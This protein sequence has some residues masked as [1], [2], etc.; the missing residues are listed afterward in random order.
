MIFITSVSDVAGFPF[1]LRLRVLQ[2]GSAK[3]CSCTLALPYFPG[4]FPLRKLNHFCSNSGR[5]PDYIGSSTSLPHQL[6]V[7]L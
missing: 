2:G 5:T 4:N 1:L 7:R 3:T 6:S